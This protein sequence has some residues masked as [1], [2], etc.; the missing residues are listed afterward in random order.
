MRSCRLAALI[1]FIPG[2][3][4]RT[5]PWCLKVSVHAEAERMC[6]AAGVDAVCCPWLRAPRAQGKL[7]QLALPQEVCPDRATAQ[8]SATTGRLVITMPIEGACPE[9][10]RCAPHMQ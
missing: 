6:Q 4:E 1:A 5:C 7:L 9:A 2:K 10:P 8:R 3:G